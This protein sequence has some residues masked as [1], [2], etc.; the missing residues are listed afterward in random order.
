V[1]IEDLDDAASSKDALCEVVSTAARL[2]RR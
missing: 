1:T 2:G